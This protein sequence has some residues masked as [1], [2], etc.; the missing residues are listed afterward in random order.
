M[1]Y[2]GLVVLLTGVKSPVDYWAYDYFFMHMIQHL[3]LMFATPT[4]VVAGTPWEPLLEA[5]PG[6]SGRSVT[7]RALA[8]RWSRPLRAAGGPAQ[9]PSPPDGEL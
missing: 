9:R 7:R 1:F 5:L 3:L 6:R 2:A 4:L 8:G